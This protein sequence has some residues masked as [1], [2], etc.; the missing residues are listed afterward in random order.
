MPVLVSEKKG[1]EDLFYF[2]IF[3]IRANRIP[4]SGNEIIYQIPVLA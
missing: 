1:I 2:Q 3:Q 4:L